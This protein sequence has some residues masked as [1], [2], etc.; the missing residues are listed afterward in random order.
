MEAAEIDLHL[1]RYA[2]GFEAAKAKAHAAPD[3]PRLL[4]AGF[5]IFDNGGGC[6]IWAKECDGF[7]IM[8]SDSEGCDY[9]PDADGYTIGAMD[10]EG[11]FL[12]SEGAASLDRVIALAAEWQA[13]GFGA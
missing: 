2:R 5:E 11:E 12:A 1:T 10:D 6:L 13:A 8:V 9:M 7:L 4:G 3:A